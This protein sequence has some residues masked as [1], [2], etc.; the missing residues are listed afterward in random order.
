MNNQIIPEN[1]IQVV[2]TLR[3]AGHE[4]LLAGGCV[5]DMLL[6]V[7]PYDYDVATSA[8][9]DE[10]VKLF[11]RS[12]TVGAQ[13]GVVVVLMDKDQIEVATFRSDIDYSDGRRPEKVIY[14]TA[15]ADALRRDFTINGMFYDPISN[16]VID[17][18]GGK[19]DLAAGIIRAIGNADQRFAEDH[20][21]M[22]RAIRFAGRF[23]YKIENKTW[24][25]ICKHSH[26]IQKISSERITTELQKIMTDS[27]RVKSMEMASET[28]LLN[29]IFSELTSEQLRI[30][31][32]T[33][34]QLAD[35]CDDFA[36]AMALLLIQCKSRLCDKICRKMTFSND[37]RKKILWLND[38]YQKLLNSIPFSKGHLKLWLAENHFDELIEFTRVYLKV[39]NKDS[40]KLQLLSNQIKELG[41]EEVAPQPYITGDDLIKMGVKPGPDMGRL[42][43][44]IYLGQLEG[45]I[46]N[47]DQAVKQVIKIRKFK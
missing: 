34:N 40:K 35:A 2:Q 32:H 41:D 15:H 19:K 38:N 33:M 23:N 47:H 12:L 9:P 5:R 29:I 8:R 27:N 16:E 4:A 22:L 24:T 25:A 21:R 28:G 43:N 45:D 3:N 39:N 17:Y 42:L 37:T 6:G 13:F 44:E 26:K 18:V 1:I 14:T 7:T 36:L 11:K 30:G 31:L 10:V 20:L 46:A